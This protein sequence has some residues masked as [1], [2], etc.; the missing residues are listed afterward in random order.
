MK[1]RILRAVKTE[2]KKVKRLI[3]KLEKEKKEVERKEEIKQKG[4]LLKYNLE[5]I[6]RG[7]SLFQIENFTGSSMKIELDPELSP[8]ENMEKYF[9]RYR[10][11]KRKQ[12]WVYKRIDHQIKKLNILEKLYDYVEKSDPE[13][14][15]KDPVEFIKKTD[16]SI[17]VE[18][19]RRFERVITADE[20]KRKGIEKTERKK[21][22]LFFSRSGKRILVGKTAEG[23]DDLLRHKA[24]GNDL[25]FHAEA[26]PGSHVILQYNK[27][28]DFSDNDIIDAATLCLYFSSLRKQKKGNIVYTFCKYVK[29]PRGARPGRVTYHQNKTL[30]LNLDENLVNELKELSLVQ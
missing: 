1:S 6:P 26:V 28:S 14:I 22:L 19:L 21:Y 12:E 9:K 17:P 20:K 27:K 3:E 11:L 30:F 18:L 13:L 10:K 5:K 8:L 15:E 2:Q 29:K 16:F 23:N 24:R 7:V 25:W 4:E